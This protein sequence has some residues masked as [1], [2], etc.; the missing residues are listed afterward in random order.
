ML[1]I[2]FGVTWI[3]EGC[4]IQQKHWPHGHCAMSSWGR[5]GRAIANAQT[6]VIK[7][8]K[9]GTNILC[10]V[11]FLSWSPSLVAD[12]NQ[13]LY[14]APLGQRFSFK[15]S[16]LSRGCLQREP[17]DGRVNRK[18]PVA[19]LLWDLRP[20]ILRF[21][22]PPLVRYLLERNTLKTLEYNATPPPSQSP[23]AEIR[24]PFLGDWFCYQYWCWR[25]GAQYR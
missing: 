1:E 6:S 13:D 20:T 5:L 22:I 11:L 25:V 8:A 24:R 9:S 16:P 19:K 21:A 17:F 23:F 2:W 12:K 15:F 7:E 10:M 3:S 4:W 14:K 18:S